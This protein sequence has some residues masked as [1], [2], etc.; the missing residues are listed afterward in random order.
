VSIYLQTVKGLNPLEAG[1]ILDV[2]PAVTVIFSPLTGRVSDRIAPRILA[3]AGIGGIAVA[4]L[5]LSTLSVTTAAGFTA[6]YL[7]ILAG[8]VALFVAPNTNAAMNAIDRHSYCVGSATLVTMRLIGQT[9][10][11]ALIGVFSTSYVADVVLGPTNYPV[12]LTSINATF[13]LFA[14]LSLVGFACSL[15]RGKVTTTADEF[16]KRSPSDS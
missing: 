8:G 12:H 13:L 11:V 10:S 2:I 14:A 3:S 15:A 7:V 1:T 16:N 6:L 4:L 9:L 5:F